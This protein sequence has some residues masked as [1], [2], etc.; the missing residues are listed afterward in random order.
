MKKAVIDGRMSSKCKNSL[1]NMGF[2]LF[3]VNNNPNLDAP[4]SAHPDISVFK[5]KNQLIIERECFSTLKEQMFLV[6]E[7]KYAAEEVEIFE[8]KASYPYDCVL[9][10]AVVGK[11][12]IGNK[13]YMNPC[14]KKTATENCM[15]FI[16][17]K[18]GYSK[19]NICIVNDSAIITEDKGIASECVKYGIDVLLLESN[20]VRL[21][22]YKY[23]FIGGATGNYT[24]E[25]GVNKILFC[26][27][28]SAHPVYNAVKSFC[29][30]HGAVPVSLSD[31][32]LYDYG[33]IIVL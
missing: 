33:S 21:D 13:K 6:G 25:N 30:S 2:K 16:D 20:S 27:D 12:I 8:E 4:V 10:F 15:D 5:C 1:E 26:G 22:G 9:N 19:C 7:N 14:I 24:D 31:E 29:E 23:G 3:Y 11:Y 28:V 18:Q 17:V 32:V